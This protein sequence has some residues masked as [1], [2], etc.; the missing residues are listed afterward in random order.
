MLKHFGVLTL[1]ATIALMQGCR[2]GNRVVQSNVD[3]G[4]TGYYATVAQTL[5]YCVSLKQ[6]DGSL[7]T[8]CG[9]GSINALPSD[10]GSVMTDPVLLFFDD[11]KSGAATI[12][13]KDLYNT[14][15]FSTQIAAGNLIGSEQNFAPE[16]FWIPGCQRK[17]K[18]KLDGRF[19]RTEGG[20]AQDGKKLAGSLSLDAS[21]AATYDAAGTDCTA[22]MTSLQ[23]CYSNPSQCGG[24]NPAENNDLSAAVQTYVGPYI[25]AGAMTPLQI[26]QMRVLY[27]EATYR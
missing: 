21:K 13:H 22:A 9:N 24:Q 18:F 2:F 8:Q 11:P 27:W 4:V 16:D 1:F 6:N 15:G 3:D 12:R 14:Y 20:I 7:A 10:L 25:Q 5:R 23:D 26:S 17:V 19:T